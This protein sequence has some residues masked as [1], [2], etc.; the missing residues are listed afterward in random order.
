[1]NLL[2]IYPCG[3]PTTRTHITHSAPTDMLRNPFRAYADIASAAASRL[4]R[5][6]VF[7]MLESG[8]YTYQA[9]CGDIQRVVL[10]CGVG[11]LI[12]VAARGPRLIYLKSN[13][14]ASRV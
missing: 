12:V 2:Q 4:A 8:F 11:P 10:F 5:K 1:M 9:R 13:L 3:D 6:V 7:G 14:K